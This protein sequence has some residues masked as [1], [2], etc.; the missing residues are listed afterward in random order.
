MTVML[1]Y[2]ILKTPIS[3]LPGRVSLDGAVIPN[4]PAS[5]QDQAMKLGFER[6]GEQRKGRELGLTLPVVEGVKREYGF[7]SAAH[8]ACMR[9]S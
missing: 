2:L 3:K 1:N 7:L 5:P 4:Y 6:K 8:E 9:M